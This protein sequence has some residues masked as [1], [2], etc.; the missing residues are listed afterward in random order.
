M[1]EVNRSTAILRPQA[2]F[3]AWVQQLPG[4]ESLLVKLEDLQHD[5]NVLL[6]PPCDD[7]NDGHAFIMQHYQQLFAAELADWCEDEQRWPQPL[8]PK[9]FQQ[10]FNIE[11]YS[12]V[13]DLAEDTLARE[14]FVPLHLGPI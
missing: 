8:T 6:I 9:L 14:T 12:I 11:I 3:L 13:T 4:N 10:W 2:P 7:L 5:C 1:H